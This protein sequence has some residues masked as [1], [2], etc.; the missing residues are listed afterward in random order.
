MRLALLMLWLLAPDLR[1]LQLYERMQFQP[2]DPKN[3]A[4]RR[5]VEI[6][7]KKEH[8]VGAYSALSD[9]F[10]PFPDDLVVAVNFDLQ[11]EEL[12]QGGGL[13]SKGIVSFNLEKL[14]EA[15]R[16]IDQVLEK[17][18][19]AEARRQRF[20]MTVPPLKFER[21]LHHELT[22]VLQQ[23][24][25]APL[26]FCEGMAQLAGDDPNVIC[27]FAHDKGKIQSIDVH[28]QDRRD[29]YARGH[30]FWKWLDSRGLA[31]RVFELTAVQ[32]RGWKVALVEATQLSW[33]VIVDM[34][35]EWS[36][37]ELD[38]LR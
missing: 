4:A 27:S 24:Y 10:G 20:V 11:G 9:R 12:A 22:H 15:Q 17:K 16:A 28:L 7:Q 3:D 32:R 6:L 14:A 35:R 29:T 1:A 2:V 18:R 30:F 33:D 36:E 23:N 25:D 38:K 34:E 37:R 21:I 13:K 26:W 31:Q 19:L 5:V 8:W